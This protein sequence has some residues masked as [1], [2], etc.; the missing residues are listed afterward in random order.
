MH[1]F[2]RLGLCVALVGLGS[3]P[4]IACNTGGGDADGTSGGDPTEAGIDPDSNPIEPS[5]GCTKAVDCPSKVCSAGGTCAAVTATDG[6]KNGDESDIDCGGAKAPKCDEQKACT[7]GADCVTGVCTDTG[8]GKQ[9]QPPAPDDGAKNGDETDVDCGGLKAPKCTDGKSCKVRN[10]CAN[11]VCNAGKCQPAICNDLSKNGTETDVDCGGSG[12]PRCADLQGCKVADDCKSGVCK[13]SGGG[14]LACAVPTP[15]DSVKN[16]METDVDCGGG[17]AATPKCAADKTCTIHDDCAS[18]GCA[19][20]GK[21]AVARSCTQKYGGDTCG[22]GGAGGRGAA[23]WESC[24]ATAPAGAGGVAMNKYKVTSGRMRAFMDRT[25]GNVRKFIGDA[26]AAGALHGA[27][28]DPAWDGYL[29]TA[30]AGCEES[31]TCAATE[32][33]DHGYNDPT[34]YQGIYSS[35]YRQLGGQM[36]DGQ[37]LGQQGCSVG[38]PGTHSYWM[39][40]ATQTKYFGDVAAEHGQAEY[41]TKPLNCVDY[42]MAQSFCIWDGGRLQTQAEYKAAGGPVDSGGAYDAPVPWGAPL[43]Q[44]QSSNTYFA[45]RFPTATDASLRALNLPITDA[46]YKYIP[47]A[48]KSIEWATYIYS[49]EYPNLVTYDYIVHLNAPGRMLARS[50]NGHADL[51]GPIMEMTSDVNNVNANP[52]NTYARWTAN[53]SFEVHQWGY[54]GWNFS[55]L[56]KYGKQ[57]LRCVYPN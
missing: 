43:P 24:C 41:D 31:G 39:D 48:G 18:D 55:L 44:A 52:K 1:Q 22:L 36:F 21:C 53:G 3:L 25:K 5:K 54:Y 8:A 34:V 16:G 40:A 11:D 10:D 26:R 35:A 30:M 38:A 2:T 57:G 6:V 14:V 7:A 47:P 15:T 50:A 42:L 17:A 37:N 49:Y 56:N 51:V 33:S 32:L 12:C 13:D 9:C 20:S 4:A 23:T 45:Y 28:M 46:N 19:Y 29:P 27:T